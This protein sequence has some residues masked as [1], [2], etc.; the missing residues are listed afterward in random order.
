M[1]LSPHNLHIMSKVFGERYH[2]PG[3]E[4]FLLCS[5]LDIEL[6][7]DHP[8]LS[9]SSRKHHSPINYALQLP[10][11]KEHLHAFY[12]KDKNE[13]CLDGSSHQSYC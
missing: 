2:H 12:L 9:G 7:W 6:E 1:F 11:M 8:S 3:L 10:E 13:S 5:R 4:G